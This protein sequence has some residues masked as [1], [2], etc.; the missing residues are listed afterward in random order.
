M[1]VNRPVGE[2]VRRSSRAGS[3]VRW[4][5]GAACLV[6]AGACA[7]QA[8]SQSPQPRTTAGGAVDLNGD[9]PRENTPTRVH[10]DN[11]NLADMTIYLYVGSQRTRL[12]R[13]RGNAGSDLTIPKSILSGVTQ[14]RFQAQ[15]LGSGRGYLSEVLAVSPGDDVDFYVPQY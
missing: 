15:P 14:V 12:G 11:Q 3:R 9:G 1:W 13:V 10:V 8:P 4:C 5:V 6:V 7:R 2:E